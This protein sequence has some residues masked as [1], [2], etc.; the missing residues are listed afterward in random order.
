MRKYY[1]LFGDG[2]KVNQILCAVL[3]NLPVFAYGASIG[4]MSPMT[5]LLQGEHSPRGTPLTAS[6]VSWM[7]AV[8]YLTS[9][10]ANYLVA[11]MGDKIGRKITLL[12]VSAM[13]CACWILKLSSMDT[14]AFIL[15]RAFVGVSMAGCYVTCP[16]YT[17]EISQD[18][19]R[20]FLGS[21]TILFHTTGNLLLYVIGDLMSYRPILWTCLAM[22]TL[23][24]VL[25]LM[26]PESP[27]YLVKQGNLEEAARVVAWLRCRK[28]DD[29]KVFQELD[30]IRKEQKKDEESSKFVFKAI[31]DIFRAFLIA[32]VIALARE[33]CGAVPVLNFAGEIFALASEGSGLVL[34]PNQQAMMLGAVQVLGST[35]A[36]SVVEKAGRKPLLFV[37]SFLSGLSMCLLASWFLAREY[38]LIWPAWM[39]ITVLCICIFCDSSGLQPLTVIVTGEIF[40]YKYRGTVMAT[41]MSV[42]SFVDFLQMLFFKPLANAVG[43]HVSFYFFG[44]ICIAAAIYVILVLP[45]TK[46]RPLEEI[47]EDMKS[48]K[49]KK[50]DIE[51]QENEK[52]IYVF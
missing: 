6:E 28:E 42:A 5:L 31:C 41:T 17:K 13:L 51:T 27:S 4:W 18:C 36:A 26:M 16:L 25:F 11:F 14:W 40:S 19:I 43:I 52:E 24:L 38:S 22:P 10:P 30:F 48:K 46:Q 23:H 2:S 9:V 39:P 37:T 35:L 1:F 34:T 21:L 49:E 3:I 20:G 12:F 32:L 15:A 44:V 33:A 47:Y 50:T 29:P 7:A 45:E 8:A